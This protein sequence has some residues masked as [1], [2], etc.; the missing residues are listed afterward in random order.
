MSEK[1]TP[2]SG[3]NLETG[4]NV[5]EINQ[6]V[7]HWHAKIAGVRDVVECQQLESQVLNEQE[8]IR[9]R[10]QPLLASKRA[11]LSKSG[12]N[13]RNVPDHARIAVDQLA[14]V[15]ET[16]KLVVKANMR[17]QEG[18]S[19]ATGIV[20]L[21]FLRDGGEVMLDHRVV[22]RD[23]FK[24]NRAAIFAQSGKGKTNLVKVVLFWV[25]FNPSYGKL[26]FDY[27][28]E[29]VPWT[30]NER[31]EKVPGLCEHPL[32]KEQFV[33]YTTKQ[34]HL[35]DETLTSKVKV[36]QLR[37]HLRSILPRDFALFWPNLTKAQQEFLFTY[38]EDPSIYDTVLGEEKH[39]HKLGAWFGKRL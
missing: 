14:W 32:S 15:P 12:R 35:Q 10:V 5:Y 13:E 36:Q 19:G 8:T 26:V 9:V 18:E 37:V 6:R 27:K 22:I 30:Q 1:N 20:P 25:A 4:M 34:R 7:A 38:D 2:N 23:Q 28:G 29:Y 16:L 3:P 33:L 31:G 11:E 39:W 17:V 21:G 24:G